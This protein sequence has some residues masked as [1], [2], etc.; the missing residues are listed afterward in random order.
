MISAIQKLKKL[1][2]KVF[3]GWWVVTAGS[4]LSAIGIGTVF[5]GFNSFF[6]P[7]IAEFGWS[8]TVTSSVFS[9]SRLE[10]G[11]EGVVIGPLIDKFGARKIAFWGV[12][13]T[14]LG[15]IA[16]LLVNKNIIT[17]YLIFGILLSLG[18]N[19]FAQ[20]AT[21]AA[22]AKWF[23]KKRS[24]AIA[25]IAAGGGVG[26][27]IFTPLLAWLIVQ[28]G[29]RWAVVIVGLIVLIIGLPAVYF[30]RKSPEEI[31]LLPDGEPILKP[32]TNT[33]ASISEHS[34]SAQVN[35]TLKEAMKTSGFWVYTLGM[36]LRSCVISGL[37]VHQIP[38]LTDMGIDYTA[39]A[40]ILGMTILISVPGRLLFGWLGDIFDK[41]RLLFIACVIQTL[42]ILIL[43]NANSLFMV[44]V[45]VIVYGLSY[46]API[47]LVQALRADLFG[48]KAY[49]TIGGVN[50]IF[51]TIGSV[52]APTVAG[53]LYDVSHSYVVAFYGFAVMAILGGI[54]YLAIRKPKALPDT[55]SGN[56]TS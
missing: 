47:P 38:Y 30:L 2:G 51:T 5:Y 44:Y 35:L 13:A 3:Y 21:Y 20:R 55:T 23:N 32:A 29:W 27:A 4:I 37:V 43:V 26:G 18:Y 52:A 39:A 15:F 8:R 48:T 42:G 36:T 49:A 50:T 53:Y 7:M 54:A 25:F 16:L 46:G 6:N 33:A 1:T 22:V 24:R 28:Y 10:G 19:A 34:Q 40:G 56:K 12:L 31:G 17:I 41:R 11:L 14:G 45:F 9:L